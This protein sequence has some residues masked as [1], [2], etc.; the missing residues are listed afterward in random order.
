MFT[1][2]DALFGAS[3]EYIDKSQEQMRTRMVRDRRQGFGQ[4]RFGRREG[5][6]RIGHKGSYARIHVCT[7]RFDERVDIVGISGERA[8]EIAARLRHISGVRPLLS[9]AIP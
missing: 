5:D 4:F 8:I 3:G 9:Q 6:R 1:F 2:G 7:R